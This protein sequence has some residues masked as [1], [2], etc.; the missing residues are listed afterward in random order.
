M[1]GVRFVTAPIQ[2]NHIPEAL[3]ADTIRLLV[4]PL[5]PQ[6]QEHYRAIKS[7]SGSI[8][9]RFEFELLKFL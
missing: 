8:S 2:Y 5:G 6:V 1:S 4:I 9:L 3:G 7:F